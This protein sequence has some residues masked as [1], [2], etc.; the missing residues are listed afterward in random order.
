MQQFVSRFSLTVML[1]LSCVGAAPASEIRQMHFSVGLVIVP[2]RLSPEFRAKH[3]FISATNL[4]SV[5][6]RPSQKHLK[7]WS[8]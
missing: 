4:T 1:T 2:Y 7:Q 6:P 5:K 3:P 8:K